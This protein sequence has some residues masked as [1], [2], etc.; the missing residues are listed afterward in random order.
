MSL[1]A[2]I[3]PEQ[4][5]VKA[6]LTRCTSLYQRVCD[7]IHG[8]FE[9]IRLPLNEDWLVDTLGL[10]T[11]RGQSNLLNKLLPSVRNIDRCERF[12][13][14]LGSTCK[15]TLN[16]GLWFSLSA[17]SKITVKEYIKISTFH[18]VEELVRAIL[19]PNAV[20]DLALDDITQNQIKS[21][22]TY[23]SHYEDSILSIRII[24]PIST[25]KA[26]SNE[27]E[28]WDWLEVFEHPES[29][30]EIAIFEFKEYIAV[31]F[32]RGPAS[33]IRVFE[34]NTRRV[35]YL[36]KQNK[37]QLYGIRR[38]SEKGVHDH[39][40]LW[41]WA[42]EKWLRLNF[43]IVPDPSV[44]RF[45]GLP[46]KAS[47]YSHTKGLPVPSL[48]LLK[49]RDD[50]LNSWNNDYLTREAKIKKGESLGTVKTRRLKMFAKQAGDLGD[51]SLMIENLKAAAMLDDMDSVTK[52]A[53][54][55]L[56][57]QPAS[58]EDRIEG[59]Y[60]HRVHQIFLGNFDLNSIDIVLRQISLKG[61]DIHINEKPLF[62]NSKRHI[63][64]K[65]KGEIH[66]LYL[67]KSLTFAIFLET[68]SDDL[69]VSPM[70]LNATG[71]FIA[72]DE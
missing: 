66:P 58:K 72:L 51:F 43:Q 14:W 3:T 44:S 34:N 12:I 40:M 10:M 2:Q 59:E 39:M 63:G 25:A 32:F 36:L 8:M 71:F 57:K 15:P 68:V 1:E 62:V 16:G 11:R 70:G 49:K 19:T 24:V 29:A 64:V 55:F 48:E 69:E 6:G 30:T 21:R 67:L 50:Q 5:F 60:W 53:Y 27:V 35:N 56:K 37:L 33:E 65:Y 42:C 38:L 22:S 23:W 20:R 45:K 28:Y 17:Q 54:W 18:N 46:N 4:L 9:G 41:Q 31:E 7:A 26:I 52:L 47:D 13:T 61:M